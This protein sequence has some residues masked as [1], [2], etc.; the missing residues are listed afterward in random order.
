M[1]KIYIYWHKC[2]CNGCGTGRTTSEDSATQLLICEPLS[3]ANMHCIRRVDLTWSFIFLL[4]HVFPRLHRHSSSW[5]YFFL[6][7]FSSWPGFFPS[8]ESA[9]PIGGAVFHFFPPVESVLTS[10]GIVFSLVY[11]WA[12]TLAGTHWLLSPISDSSTLNLAVQP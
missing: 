12:D 6:A 5:Q 2:W 11:A 7:F 4:Q 9:L 10:G 1:L 3:F 8:A